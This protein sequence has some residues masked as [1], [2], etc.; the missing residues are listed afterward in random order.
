MEAVPRARRAGRT[1]PVEPLNRN[2]R[3]TLA[4]VIV[5]AV[6]LS[7]LRAAEEDKAVKA[8]P[9]VI[10]MV[11]GVTVLIELLGKTGAMDL[12]TGML[13]NVSHPDWINGV[14][15]FVTGLVSVYASSSG[16]VLRRSCQR[17][18]A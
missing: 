10:L 11:R 16:V 13:A 6:I 3:I 15:A 1:A 7:S 18:L 9:C 5:A 12:F 4:V 14:M 17:F 2:R 8:M